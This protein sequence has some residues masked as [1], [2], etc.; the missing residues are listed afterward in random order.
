LTTTGKPLVNDAVDGPE[1][2][3]EGEGAQDR[4]DRRQAEDVA[5]V[6]HR[7]A[8]QTD[9]C[10]DREVEVAR[11]H[12]HGDAHR[13]DAVLRGQACDIDPVVLSEE[14]IRSQDRKHRERRDQSAERSE[15]G[16]LQHAAKRA[17]GT[18]GRVA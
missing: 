17:D 16:T 9:D 12:E 5:E 13:D 2:R 3:A 14:Q 11:D 18:A 1:Q 8:G 6:V 7:P 10:A 4:H 15:F